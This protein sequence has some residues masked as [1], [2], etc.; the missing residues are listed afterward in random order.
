MQAS[1]VKNAALQYFRQKVTPGNFDGLQQVLKEQDT[2]GTGF[3][4]SDAFVKCLSKSDMKVTEREVQSL[5]AE[6][7]I[8]QTGNV[9]YLEFLKFS[10]LSQMYINH[11]K[12][13]L[14]LNELDVSK[15]GMITVA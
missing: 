8:A 7:D 2:Q 14:M 1:R 4:S 5:V 12:L 9:N 11:F 15:K 13:E 3:V 6:L 10:Y